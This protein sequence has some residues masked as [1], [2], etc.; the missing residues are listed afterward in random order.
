[1]TK[2]AAN[3]SAGPIFTVA[4]EQTFPVNQR[5]VDDELAYRIMPFSIRIWAFLMKI[6]FIRN[7]ITGYYEKSNPGVW[8]GLLSRKRYIN[9][10]LDQNTGQMDGVVNLGAGFDTRVYTLGS[11]RN[12]PVWELDQTE[13][14]NTKKKRLKKI[15]G[16]I[17]ENIE[18]VGIDFDHDDVSETLGKHGYTNDKQIFFIWEGV[19]QYLEENSINEMF[20][21]LSHANSGSKICFSYVIKDFIEGKE[22]HGLN[23]LYKNYVEKKIWI[24]GREPEAWPKFLEKYGWRIVEE[25]G[26]A[27]AS[28]RYVKPT[29][30]VFKSTPI[31]RI[32]FAEKL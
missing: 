31:E 6:T 22:R 29:G 10:K 8:G 3:T 17:P 18:L 2:S 19:T 11:L 4:I 9:D 12:L 1:M 25:I 27:E 7:W 24:F 32:I 5:I 15:L 23:Y 16:N 14:I 28:E 30:R 13:I 20:D 26:A 21:F